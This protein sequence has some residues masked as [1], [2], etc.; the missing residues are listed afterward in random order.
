ML[1]RSALLFVG[2]SWFI[3]SNGYLRVSRPGVGESYV[4]RAIACACIDD[5]V[6]HINGDKLD[7]RKSN[8]RLVTHAQNTINTAIRSDNKTGTKGVRWDKVR[9]QWAAQISF[10]NRTISLGRFNCIDD[11]VIARKSAEVKHH[12]EYARNV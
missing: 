2:V 10:N 5:E 11:A 3:G 12:G 4:H 1:F 9:R 6:D 7:N 8:L